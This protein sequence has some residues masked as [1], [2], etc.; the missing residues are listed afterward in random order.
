[1]VEL[2]REIHEALIIAA[3]SRYVIQQM[4]DLIQAEISSDLSW[5]NFSRPGSPSDFTNRGRM[6]QVVDLSFQLKNHFK[7]LQVELDDVYRM[8]S[9]TRF[10]PFYDR[11]CLNDIFYD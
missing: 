10:D 3:R 1:M 5:G 9:I 8:K 11:E 4:M 2:K 7:S 6:Y